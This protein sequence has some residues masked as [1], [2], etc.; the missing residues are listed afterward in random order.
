MKE[1][2]SAE[3][4]VGLV[5]SVVAASLDKGDFSVRKEGTLQ[6]VHGGYYGLTIIVS[7]PETV[8]DEI[9]CSTKSAVENSLGQI[10]PGVIVF[11]RGCA[12]N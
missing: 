12:C 5:K 2:D 9:F 8:S 10:C 11:V 7:I 3:R 4:V 1:N 6:I